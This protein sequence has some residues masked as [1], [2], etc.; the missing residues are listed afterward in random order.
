LPEF[1]VIIFS[2]RQFDG[3]PLF[4]CIGSVTALRD[5]GEMLLWTELTRVNHE[6]EE[7]LVRR[8]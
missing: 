4:R 6:I 8:S 3:H 7:S 2:S 5:H 1:L